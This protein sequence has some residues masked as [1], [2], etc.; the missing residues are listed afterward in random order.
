MIWFSIFPLV[1]FSIHML[2]TKQKLKEDNDRLREA[3]LGDFPQHFDAVSQV[4]YAN[5]KAKG[6]W[7]KDRNKGEAIALIHSEASEIL[8]AARRDPCPEDPGD[9]LEECA[10]VVIRVMDYSYGF[11]KP[12]SLGD[13]ITAKMLK[14]MQRAIRHNKSF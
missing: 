1:I 3:V 5:A 4:V 10:D 9:E 12:H 14:N 8:E 11:L 13:A 6:F 2:L 7:P